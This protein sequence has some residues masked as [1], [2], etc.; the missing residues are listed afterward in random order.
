[1][2]HD[3]ERDKRPSPPQRHSIVLDVAAI[4]ALTVILY[5]I[6]TRL[7]QHA[8]RW[9]FSGTHVP[10]PP[11]PL[12]PLSSILHPPPEPQPVHSLANILPP[13]PEPEPIPSQAPSQP[14]D[15][16]LVSLQRFLKE[17]HVASQHIRPFTTHHH[18][19]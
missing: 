9:S 14:A 7:R 3:D 8:V 17:Q 5:F 13:L 12:P 6:M 16:S 15:T 11:K 4:I 10:D 1:M 18:E 2:Q 19:E